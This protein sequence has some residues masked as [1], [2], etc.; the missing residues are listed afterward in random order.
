[1]GVC[2]S[3]GIDGFSRL[4]VFMAV[5][6]NNR[7][8]TVLQSF[9]AATVT[10]GLPSRVRTDHGTEN[11][12]VANFMLLRRGH[13]RGSIITGRSVHN[14]RIE[15]LWV[16]LY[17]GCTHTYYDLFDFLECEGVY[18][19]NSE[20]DRWCLHF[21]FLPRIQRDMDVFRQQWNRHNL[22]TEGGLT[23]IQLFVRGA[24]RQF[25]SGRTAINDLFYE[26]DPN[27]DTVSIEELEEFGNDP[28]GPIP[29]IET[30]NAVTVNDTSCPLSA[31]ATRQLREHVNPLGNC[32]DGIGIDLYLRARS[33]MQAHI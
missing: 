12:E 27:V 24:L 7:A 19:V 31:D 23:P 29:Q 16:D 28:D 14:Q 9:I 2:Y 6:T 22:R 20:M 30:N 8:N 32:S 3:W 10:H 17:H 1:M 25:N 15:R 4:V 18:D 11:V 33:F 26:V 5:S 21:I 13:G